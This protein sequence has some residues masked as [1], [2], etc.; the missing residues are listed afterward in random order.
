[1]VSSRWRACG[2]PRGERSGSSGDLPAWPLKESAPSPA[3]VIGEL[4]HPVAVREVEKPTWLTIPER[5]LYTGILICGAVGSGKTSA[6][7]R[8]FA[9]QLLSWRAHDPEQRM[10]GLV[11]EV[12]GD[13]CHQVRDVLVAAGRGGDYIEL[14]LNG[15]WAWNRAQR[16]IP[17]G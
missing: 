14:G 8:P 11:L 13:F 17:A 5:G 1:M 10:A 16:P 3:I 15:A 6:C 7:M 2:L 4:H 12:K 9:R